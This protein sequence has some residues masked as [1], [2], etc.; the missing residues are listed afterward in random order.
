MRIGE[1]RKERKLRRGF[2]QAG[3]T[4]RRGQTCEPLLPEVRAAP[5]GD[6]CRL[7][8][9]KSPLGHDVPLGPRFKVTGKKALA[10][11]LQCLRPSGRIWLK[12]VS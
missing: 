7:E 3:N 10:Q 12:A 5:E 2:G 1:K 4:E 9:L 6:D 8:A 11:E